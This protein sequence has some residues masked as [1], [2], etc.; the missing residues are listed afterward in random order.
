MTNRKCGGREWGA[1]RTDIAAPH[2][3]RSATT[4]R[5][6]SIKTQEMARLN[7]EEMSK[8]RQQ[9]VATIQLSKAE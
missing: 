8:L 9:M 2:I 7:A 4:V 1:G 3:P 6:L 5:R